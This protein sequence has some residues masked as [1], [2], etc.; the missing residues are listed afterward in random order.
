MSFTENCSFPQCKQPGSP[1]S[2]SFIPAH[3][4]SCA[5]SNNPFTHHFMRSQTPTG[6][7]PPTACTSTPISSLPPIW[8]GFNS[9]PLL[10]LLS[11]IHSLLPLLV[12]SAWSSLT[13]ITLV[14][15]NT[16][17]VT[18]GWRKTQ[19]NPEDPVLLHSSSSLKLPTVPPLQAL[20]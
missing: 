20:S 10:L 14:E 19:N 15:Y 13:E 6:R 8:L 17:S 9:Q 12:L 16:F 4:S 18:C 7:L 2:T 11:C 5:G 3:S 1:A